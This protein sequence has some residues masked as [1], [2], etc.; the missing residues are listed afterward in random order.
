MLQ[1]K[2]FQT[3][4]RNQ[5]LYFLT[6]NAT[7]MEKKA[8]VSI[9]SYIRPSENCMF[10]TSQMTSRNIVVVQALHWPSGKTGRLEEEKCAFSD[11]TVTFQKPRHDCEYKTHQTQFPAKI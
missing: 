1:S 7:S 9:C 6:L 4:S 10:F 3:I 11:Y 8:W 5:L 2:Q